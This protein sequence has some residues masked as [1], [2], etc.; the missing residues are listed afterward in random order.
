MT[1]PKTLNYYWRLLV[2]GFCFLIF[3]PG[4]VLA[5]LVL[6]PLRIAPIQE[7]KKR[8]LARRCIG[9]MLTFYLAIMV[10]TGVL[11]LTVNGEERLRASGSKFFIANHPTLI[12]A[13]VLISLIPD[14]VCV[15]KAELN[16]HF[17]MRELLKTTGY[18]S[19]SEPEDFLRE[20]S[21]TLESGRSLLLFPEGTRSVPG[22][23]LKLLRGA[24]QIALRIGHPLTPVVITCSPPALLKGQKWYHVPRSGPVTMKF[25]LCEDIHVASFQHEN[26]GISLKSRKL[27]RYL[28]EYFHQQ[29]QRPAEQRR[30]RGEPS[31]RD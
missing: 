1:C 15:A 21:R 18:I 30:S 7:E 5:C 9:R 3:G 13:V 25:T 20:C 19:N 22:E 24:A 29:L 14:V 10:K 4:A 12:D 2:T 23:P 16:R 26:E 31:S 6:L 17:F 8:T 27:T 28:T 11:R